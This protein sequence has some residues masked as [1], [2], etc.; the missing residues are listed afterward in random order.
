LYDKFAGRWLVTILASNNGFAS[1]TQC[2]A[3]STSS[4]ATSSYNR[5]AFSFGTNL[6]DYPKFGVWPSLG[7]QGYY[8][9]YP[10]AY[11]AS[12]NIFQNGSFVGAEACAYDRHMMLSGSAAT[13]QCFQRSTSDFGLLPSDLDG[14]MEPPLGSP[15]FF[16]E[17]ANSG[18]LSLYRFLVNFY[19]PGSTTFTGPVSIPVAAFSEAC[20]GGT[21][22]P[23]AGT[24]QL[25][26]SLGDRLMFRLAYRNFVTYHALVVAHSIASGSTVGV[27]WYEIHDPEGTPAVYQSG[28]YAPDSSFRW[29]PSIAM[30]DLADISVGYSVSSSAMHPAIRYSGRTP[31]DPLGTLESESAI[32]QGNGRKSVPRAGATIPA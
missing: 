14:P 7:E 6:P 11:Y 12:Y 13:A 21:C 3:V 8:N 20:E 26:D 2:I 22:I 17:I 23:Q 25:L 16:V 29:M 10:G 27:R 4:D 32:I 24:T 30:D 9:G 1:A 31:N 5:Y 15:N 28:T 19:N 18:S